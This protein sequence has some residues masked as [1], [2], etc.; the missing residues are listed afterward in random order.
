MKRVGSE[1]DVRAV[2]RLIELV[3]NGRRGDVVTI[4]DEARTP[5]LDGC[6]GGVGETTVVWLVISVEQSPLLVSALV[7]NY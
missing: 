4:N 7:L 6:A 2:V 1:T 5:R 3:R